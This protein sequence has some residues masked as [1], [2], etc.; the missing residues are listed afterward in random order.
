MYM[1]EISGLIGENSDW[2]CERIDF[3]KTALCREYYNEETNSVLIGEQGAEAFWCDIGMGNAE[4]LER[5]NKNYQNLGR[6]D[7]GIF[8][9]DVLT[10]V[11]FENGYSDTAI[12]L[13]SSCK[14]NT[15]GYQIK[16]HDATTLWEYWN[17]EESH[18]HPMF[19]ACVKYLFTEIL[20]IKKDTM[21][22]IEPKPSVLLKNACGKI[23]IDERKVS[24]QYK[25]GNDKIIFTIS[26]EIPVK[27]AWNNTEYEIAENT[28]CDYSFSI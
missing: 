24:V 3:L 7:T 10:R 26:T 19:G 15:F 11:L 22:R 4:M 18:N 14:E 27:F 23:E 5:I 21:L 25:F 16:E 9:T 8:G 20:G 1:K 28:I 17:G 2:I 12:M 6:F 13:M